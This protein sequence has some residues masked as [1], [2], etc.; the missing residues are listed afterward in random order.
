MNDQNFSETVDAIKS[1]KILI[2]I[3]LSTGSIF[4]LKLSPTYFY[5]PKLE[6]KIL[7]TDLSLLIYWI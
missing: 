2:Y 6:S 5:L 4:L 3:L 1:L 7:D